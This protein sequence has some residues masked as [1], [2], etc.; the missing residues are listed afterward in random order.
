MTLRK[1]N[2][3]YLVKIK[4]LKNGDAKATRVQKF[5]INGISRKDLERGDLFREILMTFKKSFKFLERDCGPILN[6]I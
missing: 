2:L 5:E 1:N 6:L 3:I 4:I